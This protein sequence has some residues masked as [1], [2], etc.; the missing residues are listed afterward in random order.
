MQKK[1]FC[2]PFVIQGSKL[3]GFR[4]DQSELINVV[5]PDGVAEIA[6]EVF[7]NCPSLTCVTLPHFLLNVAENAFAKCTALTNVVF[8]PPASFAY[9]AW[10]LGKSRNRSNWQR[11]SLK[12][13]CGIL[14]HIKQLLGSR[15]V[16]SLDRVGFHGCPVGKLKKKNVLKSQP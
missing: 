6:G 2:S 16:T 15:D 13:H 5:I 9:I 10:A 8:R 11:T 7:Q 4:G 12:Q 14:H 3:V 1:R